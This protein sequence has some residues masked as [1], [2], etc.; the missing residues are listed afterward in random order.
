MSE[1]VS[2]EQCERASKVSK[3]VK[4]ASE[5]SE[6]ASKISKRANEWAQQS[7]QAK[8]VV[9]HPS[10]DTPQKKNQKTYFGDP[11]IYQVE[12]MDIPKQEVAKFS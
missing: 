9:Q 1:R 8:Q 5:Q 11:K 10:L 12:G 7:A 2:S 4:W 6:R 3:R